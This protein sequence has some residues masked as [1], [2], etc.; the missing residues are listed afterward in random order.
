MA[1][2]TRNEILDY[3]SYTDKRPEVRPA[4]LAAKEL[5]R[6]VLAE[7]RLTFLLE[8]HD[9]VWYQIQEMMRVE[10]IVREKDIQHEIDTYNELC[11]ANG[12]LRGC[13]L[14]SILDPVERSAKLCEWVGLIEGLYVKLED[15]TKVRAIPD[16]RQID[17]GKLSAVQYLHF[18]V[19]GHTPVAI[20]CDFAVDNLSDEQALTAEQQ[21]EI[22]ADLA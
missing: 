8:N 19:K 13:L 11:T 9:T 14:I 20:G 4:I 15:G 6:F 2:V 7:N 18:D 5:R 17:D 1:L 12:I 16:G 21:R 10:R 3:V 22:G